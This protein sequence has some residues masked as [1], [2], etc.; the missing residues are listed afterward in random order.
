VQGVD[1][2]K[3]VRL[4]GPQIVVSYHGVADPRPDAP[5]AVALE[6]PND[7]GCLAVPVYGSEVVRCD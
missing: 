6:R 7:R 2:T 1:P 3:V 4:P 5:V